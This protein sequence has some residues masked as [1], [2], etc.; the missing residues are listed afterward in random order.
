M[1]AAPTSSEI[2]LLVATFAYRRKMLRGALQSLNTRMIFMSQ[3]LDD[4]TR[5]VSETDTVITSAIALI[6]G[7]KAALDAAGTDAVKL[8]EL[9]ASLDRQQNALAAAIVA[10]TPAAPAA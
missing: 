6:Q 7:L 5:E 10:G 2:D 9:S 3:A 1:S 8:A 4:L